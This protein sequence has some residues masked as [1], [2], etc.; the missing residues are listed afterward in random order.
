MRPPVLQNAWTARCRAPRRQV[1]ITIDL[2]SENALLDQL[3]AESIG[4]AGE[5]ELAGSL[6]GLA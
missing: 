6:A 5:L 4:Q 3:S 2:R 1:F